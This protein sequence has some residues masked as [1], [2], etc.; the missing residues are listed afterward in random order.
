MQTILRLGRFVCVLGIVLLGAVKPVGAQVTVDQARELAKLDAQKSG[1]LGK[2]HYLSVHARE[3][4]EEL[5]YSSISFGPTGF[6]RDPYIF[7]V[8]EDGREF[9]GNA[10]KLH[11]TMDAQ[12]FKRLVAVSARSGQVFQLDSLEHFNVLTKAYRVSI[13]NNSAAL[14][15]L[16]FY[17]AVAPE[18][19][20]IQV[21]YNPLQLKQFAE[22]AFF[23]V[24]PTLEEADAH[25]DPW[26]K[27]NG[28]AL[29]RQKLGPVTTPIESG[30]L[31]TFL[32]I[33]SIDKKSRSTGPGLLRLSLKISRD[34]QLQPLGREPIYPY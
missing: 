16:N 23:N 15:Y 3:D 29:C 2:D 26:W 22:E 27:K 19:L 34:G 4:L 31:V 10:V 20:L 11:T 12:P 33:S 1:D 30:Y 5:F 24:Y 17:L 14:D 13:Q 21:P 6:V 7:E 18:R 25:F 28:S 8:S 9:V 32:I